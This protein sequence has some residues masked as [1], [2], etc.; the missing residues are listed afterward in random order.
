MSSPWSE[1]PG[2]P[3]PTRWHGVKTDAL[4]AQPAH[5]HR[6]DHGQDRLESPVRRARGP[7]SLPP[8]DCGPPSSR[9]GI[10]GSRRPALCEGMSAM[11]EADR[12]PVLRA[13]AAHPG[14]AGA[15]RPGRARAERRAGG[16]RRGARRRRRLRAGAPLRPAAGLAVPAAGGDGRAHQPHR[17]GHRRHRHALREPAVHGRGGRGRRPA[18]RRPAAARRQP[19]ITGD[20]AARLRGVR[21]RAAGGQQRRRPRPGQDRAVP[22]GD[23]AGRP[24]STP[25]RG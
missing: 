21:L 11:A 24:W 15:D 22:R 19:G 18:Q 17:D 5:R 16:R 23:R 20:G 2:S 6:D 8:A 9:A 1:P 10:T 14:L 4:K 13:L 7:Q 3:A 25:T 12:V